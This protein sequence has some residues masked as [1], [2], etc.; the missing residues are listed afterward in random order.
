M[1]LLYN[2]FYQSSILF[3]FLKKKMARNFLDLATT[4]ENLGATWLLERKVNFVPCCVVKVQWIELLPGVLEVRGLTPV[5]DLDF[6]L[7]H[8][9]MINTPFTNILSFCILQ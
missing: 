1:T 5:W 3:L 9:M 6:F 2:A 7:A 8:V 4:L